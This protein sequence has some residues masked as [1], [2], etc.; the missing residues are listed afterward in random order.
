MEQVLEEM[1]DMMSRVKAVS[2]TMVKYDKEEAAG[3]LV[4]ASLDIVHETI[5]ELWLQT[6]DNR[7]SVQRFLDN[8]PTAPVEDDEE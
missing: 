2:S 4:C 3:R 5:H 1:T 7:V 8:L 6:T